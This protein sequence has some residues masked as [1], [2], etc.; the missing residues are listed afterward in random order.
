MGS[1]VPEAQPRSRHAGAVRRVCSPA[2]LGTT[3]P[4]RG[5]PR[6]GRGGSSRQCPWQAGRSGDGHTL[7]K[8]MK[9][10]PASSAGAPYTAK[11]RHPDKGLESWAARSALQQSRGWPNRRRPVHRSQLGGA[12]DG[13]PPSGG[14]GT[15]PPQPA[16]PAR[17]QWEPRP[18]V[19]KQDRVNN[20]R[21]PAHWPAWEPG[22]WEEGP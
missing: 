11:D 2:G 8:G 19:T 13:R 12:Q 5:L 17:A 6:T 4:G 9:S 22:W 16:Q 15:A 20:P 10:C 14:R 7:C 18:G 21:T 1:Q 3:S